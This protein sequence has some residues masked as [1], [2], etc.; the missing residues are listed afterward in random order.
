MILVILQFL[1]DA[2][3]FLFI[4]SNPGS[5]K[6]FFEFNCSR[7]FLLADLT[8]EKEYVAESSD[9]SEP[10]DAKNGEYQDCSDL[11]DDA[12]DKQ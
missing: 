3:S 6:T 12:Y 1:I 7:M 8:G 10:G 2:F 5:I 4:G 11:N 9:D